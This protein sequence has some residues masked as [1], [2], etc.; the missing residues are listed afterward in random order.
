MGRK[1]T[2]ATGYRAGHRPVESVA[3]AALRLGLLGEFEGIVAFYSEVP[4]CAF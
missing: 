4:D 2:L 1:R 3:L